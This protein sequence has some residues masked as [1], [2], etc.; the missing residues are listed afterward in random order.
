MMSPERDRVR[1]AELDSYAIE[2]TLPG[3][4]LIRL[5]RRNR[6]PN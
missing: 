6:R 5:I 4:V 2:D 3:L 1:G